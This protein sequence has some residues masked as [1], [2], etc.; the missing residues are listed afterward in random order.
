[1]KARIT[2][3]HKEDGFYSY[4]KDLIG[5]TGE[6]FRPRKNSF[7][8]DF[9]VGFFRFTRPHKTWGGRIFFFACQFEEIKPKKARSKKG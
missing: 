6:L 4:R 7:I 1:M 5:R 9:Y 8:K 2:K 3:I